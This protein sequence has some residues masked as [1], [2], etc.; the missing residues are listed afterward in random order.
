MLIVL[1][2]LDNRSMPVEAGDDRQCQGVLRAADGLRPRNPT[3]CPVF[4]GRV[5][6]LVVRASR[7]AVS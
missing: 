6:V 3:D 5:L 2:E 4:Q 1:T 7:Y